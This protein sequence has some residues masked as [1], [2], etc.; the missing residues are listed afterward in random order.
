MTGSDLPPHSNGRTAIL[1]YGLLREFKTCAPS[2][3][4]H[5][6]EPNDADVFYFGP[7]HTDKPGTNF[8]PK[9]SIR[10]DI[11]ANPK[12]QMGQLVSIEAE[13]VV[14]AYGDRLVAS[15]F[16]DVP[17]ET[18]IQKAREVCPREDWLGQMDPMRML[19]LFY[20]MTGVVSLMKAHEEQSGIHYDTVIITRPD[21]AFYRPV[22]ALARAGEIHIP[23]GE[24]FGPRGQKNMGN[25]Q[26]FYY[27]NVLTGDYI[28]PFE[29]NSFNDQLMMFER[30]GLHLF[31]RIYDQFIEYMQMKVPPSPEG[32]LYLHLVSRGGLKPKHHAEWAY[33]IFRSGA[34]LVQ[35]VINTDDIVWIDRSHPSAKAMLKAKPIRWFLR[36]LKRSYKVLKHR[37]FS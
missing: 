22:T 26:G 34:P 19:S 20:N 10:G 23:Y 31:E 16:H 1:L 30:G 36:D 37:Y 33:E 6:V 11:V 32:L 7:S 4:R 18:F 25:A 5:A 12:N 28:E 24:G 17:V 3:L 35:S 2:F 21:L 9:V 27:K 29:A 15:K 14:M 13:A 8:Q